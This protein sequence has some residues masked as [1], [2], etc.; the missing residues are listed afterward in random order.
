MLI[1]FRMF[2]QGLGLRFIARHVS[3]LSALTNA[4]VAALHPRTWMMRLQPD[5]PLGA[6]YLPR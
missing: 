1:R 4:D 2:S 3:V 5:V 6:A